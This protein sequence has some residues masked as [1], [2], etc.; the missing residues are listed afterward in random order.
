VGLVPLA[1]VHARCA[2]IGYWLGEP[3]WGRGIMTGGVRAVTDHALSQRGFLRLEAPVF[4]ASTI[5][6]YVMWSIF[7]VR[8]LMS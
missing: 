4:V 1:D 8:L 2:H 7:A 5:V 3:F 6:L